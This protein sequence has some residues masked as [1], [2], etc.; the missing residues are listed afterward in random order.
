L[1]WWSLLRKKSATCQKK[2]DRDRRNNALH[3]EPQDYAINLHSR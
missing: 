2:E 3:S 1:F